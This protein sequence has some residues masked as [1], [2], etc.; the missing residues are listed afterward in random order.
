MTLLVGAMHEVSVH[1][2]IKVSELCQVA[3]S[4]VLT[5]VE[6][7]AEQCWSPGLVCK[8]ILALCKAKLCF[9][10]PGACFLVHP[11]LAEVLRKNRK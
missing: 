6:S 7:E 9:P 4:L 5:A 11:V 10:R 1:C 8:G 3:Q 2:H